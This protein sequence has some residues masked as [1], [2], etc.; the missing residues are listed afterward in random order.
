MI[1]EHSWP[2]L[3]MF[4]SFSENELYYSR[5]KQEFRDEIWILLRRGLDPIVGL[6]LPQK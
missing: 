3:G 1:K 4:M 2:L 6:C 5:N